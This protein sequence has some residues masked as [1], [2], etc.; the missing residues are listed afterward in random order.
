MLQAAH[1]RQFVQFSSLWKNIKKWFVHTVVANI[2]KRALQ[3]HWDASITG[4]ERVFSRLQEAFQR[5]RYAG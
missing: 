1:K 4:V 5:E 2:N 3:G